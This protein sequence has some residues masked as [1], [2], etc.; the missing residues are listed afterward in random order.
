M[1]VWTVVLT[2]DGKAPTSIE[3]DGVKVERVSSITIRGAARE[4]PTIVLTIHPD[5]VSVVADVDE[6]NVER[7]PVR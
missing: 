7:R 6:D 1:S 4:R 2:K 3:M 5:R